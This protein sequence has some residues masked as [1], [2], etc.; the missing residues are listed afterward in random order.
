MAWLST[1]TGSVWLN[2][3]AGGGCASGWSTLADGAAGNGGGGTALGTMGFD[4][5]AVLCVLL[6][7]LVVGGCWG[8]GVGGDGG[9][10]GVGGGGVGGVGGA[11][12]IFGAGG[13]CVIVDDGVA[14]DTVAAAGS[15]G[16]LGF[17]AA[18]VMSHSSAGMP[19]SLCKNTFSRFWHIMTISC[20]NIKVIKNK[21]NIKSPYNG[22]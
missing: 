1:L 17:G 12:G 5:C 2:T 21:T 22:S 9:D 11:T 10:G 18:G 19:A 3:P 7:L 16:L 20:N 4:V 14:V 15:F 6:T 13:A 8:G